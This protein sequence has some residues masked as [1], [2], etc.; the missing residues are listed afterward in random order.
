MMSAEI[1]MWIRRNIFPQTLIK[2]SKKK[3]NIGAIH[4]LK[5]FQEFSPELMVKPERKNNVKN[6]R[7]LHMSQLILW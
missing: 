6:G 3:K 2:T 7:P 1:K 4:N 5:T